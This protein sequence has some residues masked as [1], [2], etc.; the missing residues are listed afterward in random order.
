[1]HQP[2]SLRYPVLGTA[3]QTVGAQKMLIERVSPSTSLA[4]GE[5][6]GERTKASSD[7][8]K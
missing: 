1:M 7:E 5:G 2:H 6:R 4:A 8:M 3:P